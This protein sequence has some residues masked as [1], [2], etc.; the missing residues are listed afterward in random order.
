[1]FNKC[2]ANIYIDY[3]LIIVSFILMYYFDNLCFKNTLHEDTNYVE[4][5]LVYFHELTNCLLLIYI[6]L[7]NIQI[8]LSMLNFIN[9]ILSRIRSKSSK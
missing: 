8:K 9:K 2:K 3:L 4:W 1:M 5:W 6:I 7:R